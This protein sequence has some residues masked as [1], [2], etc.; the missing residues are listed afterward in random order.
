MTEGNGGPRRSKPASGVEPGQPLAAG[1]YVVATPIGNLGDI[2][3]RAL[4]VLAGANVIA[5]EDTRATAKLLARHGIRTP[6]TR[7]D[8]HAGARARPRLLARMQDG[9]AVALVAD[10]GT[11]L[12]ADPGYVLVRAAIDAAIPVVPVPGPSAVLAALAAA[13]LPTD[14]FHFV[15]FLPPRR[16]ARVRALEALKP[17]EATLVILES[18]RRLAASLEDMTRILGPRPA[19]IA[20]ELTKRFEE[21]RRD[22]LA[23]LAAHYRDQGPPKGEAVIVVGGA[24][25]AQRPDETEL[26]AMLARARKTM[27]VC[28]AVAA[29]TAVSGVARREVYA[30]ALKLD[31]E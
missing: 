10:A 7:Y 27:S 11:P 22:T 6:T 29:V 13:G 23:G 17:I 24:A 25:A 12:I 5:C 2:T 4:A 9:K 8:D 30:L 19:A 1:L 20:R 14:R 28:E 21:V 26:R 15:G 31:R 16:G 3:L 18:T